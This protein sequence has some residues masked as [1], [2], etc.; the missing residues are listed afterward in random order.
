MMVMGFEGD[1]AKPGLEFFL[2]LSI[3]TFNIL[4]FTVAYFLA[5]G[6]GK[7]FKLGRY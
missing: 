3:I 2:I 4:G 6:V 7:V 1:P 5:V